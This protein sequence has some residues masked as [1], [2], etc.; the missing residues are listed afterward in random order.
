M[1]AADDVRCAA[2]ALIAELRLSGADYKWVEPENLHLTLRFFGETPLDRIPE[3]EA[4]LR[5]AA[6]RPRFDI[7]FGS[8]GAFNSWDDPKVVWVGVG[9]GAAELGALAEALGAAE[10]GRP[11]SAHLTIGR[12][13]GRSGHER[14]R[15]A[16][17]RAGFPQMRQEVG[18]VALFES[19]LTPR[20]P[21]Y[22]V[23]AEA[24]IG[25]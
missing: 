15:A 14:L 11:F 21:T 8:V 2:A 16:A 4:L 3:L 19:R 1:P 24:Q 23:R 25:I 17:L 7:S 5:R 6:Q 22:T 12:R 18:R 20:G 9:S 10:E 13:R